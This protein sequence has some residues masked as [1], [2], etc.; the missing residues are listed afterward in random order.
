MY[1]QSMYV[2]TFED[3]NA[4][5]SLDNSILTTLIEKISINSKKEIIIQYKFQDEYQRLV[6]FANKNGGALNE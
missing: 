4:D 1:H 3:F 5:F 2:K 6:D